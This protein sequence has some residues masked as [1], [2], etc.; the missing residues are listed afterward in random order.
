MNI[1]CVDWNAKVRAKGA[2]SKIFWR[3]PDLFAEQ[4]HCSLESAEHLLACRQ[5]DAYSISCPVCKTSHIGRMAK[6]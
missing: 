3:R 2:K 6:L 1:G 4:P 5:I